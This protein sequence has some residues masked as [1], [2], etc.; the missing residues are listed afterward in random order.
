MKRF[1]N[2][3]DI[4]SQTRSA[5]YPSENGKAE[6]GIRT[7]KD[8]TRN[9]LLQSGL[10]QG[11]WPYA[12]LHAVAILN[13]LPRSHN[14]SPMKEFSRND[15]ITI[16]LKYLELKDTILFQRD[17]RFKHFQNVLIWV[18]LRSTKLTVSGIQP[19]VQSYIH[20]IFV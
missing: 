12:V 3:N 8:V 5:H 6:R 19:N 13:V 2:R 11:F 14:L 15:L 18:S 20:E 7:V 4:V 17:E 9:I 1:C 16:V 10:T